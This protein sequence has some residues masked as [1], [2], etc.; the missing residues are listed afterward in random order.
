MV[1]EAKGMEPIWIQTVRDVAIIL[2]ALESI[3]IGA[4]IV[5]LVLQIQRLTKLLEEEI[6]P[7]LVSINE[8]MG[9][10]RGT[11]NFISESVVSPTIQA[12]SYGAAVREA[13]TAVFRRR[14]GK[15]S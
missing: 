10:V 15:K 12:L 4:M 1:K 9:T 13:A 6:K 8:T 2:L 3:V 14:S 7:L 11:T 5:I